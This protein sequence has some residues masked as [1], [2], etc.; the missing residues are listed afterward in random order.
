MQIHEWKIIYYGFPWMYEV[1]HW[2]L[3]HNFASAQNTFKDLFKIEM[4][5]Y[6]I[7]LSSLKERLLGICAPLQRKIDM[8][9]DTDHF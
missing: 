9:F 8:L 5:N 6:K 1:H 3:C 7:H 4:K 2:G